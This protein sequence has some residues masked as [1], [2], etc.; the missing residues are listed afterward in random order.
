MSS[1]ADWNQSIINEFRA[2]GGK[3]G[4]MFEGRTL[5]ILHTNGARS[6]QE[7]VNPVAYTT[8]GER[9]VIF[10]SKA[11][12]PSHPAWYFNLVANP[13]VEI[14]VGTETYQARAEVAS[15]PERTRL[16]AKMV[17]EMPGFAE[18][19]QKTS[20][21]IPVITLTKVT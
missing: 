4:G 20:R 11:G 10:A 2:N 14:E 15:E 16:Y 9:L 13:L 19:Q 5:L 6:G 1:P 12:A 21:I 17:S 18:Y 7:R 3:V 8:D